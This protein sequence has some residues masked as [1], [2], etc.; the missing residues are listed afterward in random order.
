[1]FKQTSSCVN[2]NIDINRTK[3]RSTFTSQYLILLPP[4]F[5]FLFVM[6]YLWQMVDSNYYEKEKGKKAH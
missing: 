6:N 2:E 5:P 3:T 4:M 1:M